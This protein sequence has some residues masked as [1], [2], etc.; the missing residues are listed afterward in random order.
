MKKRI[1][2]ILKITAYLVATFLTLT[3]ICPNSSLS[4]TKPPNAQKSDIWELNYMVSVS[5]SFHVKPELGSGDPDVFYEIDRT[6]EG[7]AKLVFTKSNAQR[8]VFADPSTTQVD[9]HIDD[10]RKEISDLTCEE[11][12]TVDEKWGGKM[13]TLTGNPKF[14]PLSQL[15]IDNEKRNYKTSLSYS[16]CAE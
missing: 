11:Y 9:I 3:I 2:Q 4:Q 13:S 10:T 12:L 1:R 6:Y 7:K 8:F 14:H 16:V 5:G 15:L